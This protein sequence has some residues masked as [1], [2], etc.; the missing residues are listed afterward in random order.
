MSAQK[1]FR[2]FILRLLIVTAAIFL[3]TEISSAQDQKGITINL[4][5]GGSSNPSGQVYR[6]YD[7]VGYRF[8]KHFEVDAGLPVYFVRA[9]S[10]GLA[11]GFSSHNGIGNVFLELRGIASG[12]EWY[13][14]SNLRGTAPTGSK[15][16][17]FSTGRATVE[18]TNYLEKSIG[19][20]T[21]FGS[22]GI[23]NT[24]S[25]THFFIR[26]F[27]SLGLVGIFE[28]GANVKIAGPVSIGGSLYADVPSGQQK[29][30]SKL[31]PQGRINTIQTGGG[32]GRVFE[33]QNAAVGGSEADK[34]HG[35]SAWLDFNPATSVSLEIGYSRSTQYDL[36]TLFFM[37]GFDLGGLVKK[38][39]H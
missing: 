27:T 1:I 3:A 36:D 29:V 2:I 28:G 7:A 13:F 17:G 33:S 8:S 6:L 23:A 14:S 32:H 24:I 11:Q 34:D 31:L 5:L 39:I 35:A 18:W 12:S 19:R 9:S 10:S 30:F 37:V 25:D 4:N 21:P 15:D 22:V 38:P 20:F 16:D 26:P